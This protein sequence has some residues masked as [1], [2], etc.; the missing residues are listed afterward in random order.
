MCFRAVVVK[1]YYDTYEKW[2][3]R[4]HWGLLILRMSYRCRHYFER[5][6]IN[7]IWIAPRMR[8]PLARIQFSV[9]KTFT[10]CFVLDFFK[11]IRYQHAQFGWESPQ[12]STRLHA[13]HESIGPSKFGIYIRCDG[14]MQSQNCIP[15]C[16]HF[17][18]LSSVVCR[19]F[20][21][22]RP[23]S[24]EKSAGGEKCIQRGDAASAVNSIYFTGQECSNSTFTFDHI[25]VSLH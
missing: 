4:V 7:W 3:S 11:V 18:D 14:C 23:S 22:I 13:L 12:A 20:V 10:K 24:T 1:Q 2:K 8:S 17:H 15:S 21:R 16:W 19:V 5:W 6:F 9:W 25:F